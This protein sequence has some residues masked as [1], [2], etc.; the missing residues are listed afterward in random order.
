MR[1]SG[2][3]VLAD[4]MVYQGQML[5]EGAEPSFGEVV[6]STATTG[7]TEILSDPSYFGQIV[8]MANP[9]IGNYGVCLNDC[10]SDG[11]KV[12]GLVVRNLSQRASSWRQDLSLIDWLLQCEVPVLVGIDTRCLVQRIRDQGHMIGVMAT[13]RK[14]SVFDLHAQIKAYPAADKLRLASL[15]SV[16]SAVIAKEHL[17]CHESQKPLWRVVALDFGIKKEILRYLNFVGCEVI[18]VPSDTLVEEIW[19]YKPDGVFL[20]N[21]PGDPSLEVDAIKTVASLIGKIPI[22]GVCLGHQI[23]AQALG[24][25]TFKLKFGHRGSN[26]PVKSPDG[27]IMISA[28]NHGFAVQVNHTMKGLACDI[29]CSD[30]TNEGFDCPDLYAFSAQFHPEGAPGPKDGVN[31]FKKF[32]FLMESWKKNMSLKSFSRQLN[33]LR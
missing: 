6:F 4:G 16:S 11:I 26:H 23:L 17:D 10:Q 29:N 20:S 14:A 27:H 15:V 28:Q 25:S 18:L 32:V 33:D 8:V 9:E 19:S 24:F 1:Q 2:S 22:F 5:F 3:L 12:A 7:Y 30:G 31:Y 13:A 21:G